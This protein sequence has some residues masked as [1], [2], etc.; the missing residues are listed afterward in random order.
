M[1]QC[2][3]G[4]L[5]LWKAEPTFR[6]DQRLLKQIPKQIAVVVD[7]CCHIFSCKKAPEGAL[8]NYLTNR[9]VHR[10]DEL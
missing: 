9:I 2:D 8:I 3:A 10:E 4:K 1:Y 5:L 7:L 6:G